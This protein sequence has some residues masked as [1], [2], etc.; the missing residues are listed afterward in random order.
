MPTKVHKVTDM[1][2]FN[3]HVWIW[4]LDHKDGW[5][6]KNW[7]FQIVGL[8][9]I[10]ESP[11]DSNLIK[12]VNLKGNQPTLHWKDWCWTWSSNTLATWYEETTH[13]ERPWYGERLKVKGEGGGRRWDGYIASATQWTQFEQTTGDRRGQTSLACYCH[14]VPKSETQLNT[15]KNIT[16]S[17]YCSYTVQVCCTTV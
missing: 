15:N 8:D 2:F 16:E 9:K 17:L 1:I 12:P 3:S 11:L 6:P 13:W 7:C 4:E 14:G 10:L 5:A